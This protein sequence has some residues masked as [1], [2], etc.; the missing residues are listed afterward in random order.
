MAYTGQPG[1][2]THNAGHTLD[3]VFSNVPFVITEVADDLHSGS[4]HS[5][6]L[7]RVPC[8]G[9]EPL[10]QFHYR[11]PQ[12]SISRFADV[13]HT[14]MST[15][16][17]PDTLADGD[18]EAIDVWIQGFNAVWLE[19]LQAAG[20]PDRPAARA[21]PWWTNECQESRNEWH[22]ARRQERSE[23]EVSE[24]HRDFHR[25]VRKAKRQYWRGVIDGVENDVELFKV[26]G[27]HKLG[28]RLKNPPLVVGGVQVES[29]LEKAEVLA[30]KIMQRFSSEDDLEGDPLEGWD[31]AE[32]SMPL[33]CV[34][35]ASL[36][37]VEACTIGVTS[38]SPGV[39]SN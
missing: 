5:T 3:I 28:P 6:L 20:K 18:N 35:D 19:A 25:T 31:S 14:C 21:A 9:T 8:R 39:D 36:E 34:G 12:H 10:E 32:V 2:P 23:E 1:V 17:S 11:V 24:L 16:R 33:N 26:V 37:E 7:T 27:W 38:T 15:L 29:P 13:I 4:D 30:Q 22:R